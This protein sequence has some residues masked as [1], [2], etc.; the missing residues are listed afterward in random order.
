LAIAGRYIRSHMFIG[1]L[2]TALALLVNACIIIYFVV[3]VPTP[4]GPKSAK[5]FFSLEST[6]SKSSA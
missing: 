5:I 3:R 1:F 4:L 2:S 6:N